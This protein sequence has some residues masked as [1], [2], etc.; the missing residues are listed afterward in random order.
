MSLTLIFSL[1]G[2]LLAGYMFDTMGNYSL[3]WI[4]NL[5][6]L[7]TGIPMILIMKNPQRETADASEKP[8]ECHDCHKIC[9][10]PLQYFQD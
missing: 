1:S 3:A 7:I 6:L 4:I 5:A 2:P 9:R 8:R 10:N